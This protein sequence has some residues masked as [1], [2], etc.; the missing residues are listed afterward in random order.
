M[1]FWYNHNDMKYLFNAFTKLIIFTLVLALS[2]G[3]WSCD[4]DSSD[5][6]KTQPSSEFTETGNSSESVDE[7]KDFTVED[8]V[9]L[10]NQ[11]RLVTEIFLCNSLWS[12]ADKAERVLV[13]EGKAYANFSEI[14]TLV[15]QTYLSDSGEK[16]FFFAYPENQEPAVKSENGK[17]SV[18]RH[19]G[20]G[21]TDFADTA[22][23]SVADTDKEDVKEISFK[24]ISGKEIKAKAVKT[25]EGTWLLEKGICHLNPVE[26]DFEFSFDKLNQ[27]SLKNLNGKIL[28]I[29]LFV[30]DKETKITEADETFFHQKVVS[31]TQKLAENVGAYGLTP[32]FDFVSRHYKHK[33]VLGTRPVDFDIMFAQTNMGDLKTFAQANLD[34]TGYDN[35]FFVVCIKKEAETT[36]AFYDGT[37]ENHL[38][39]GERVL[40]GSNVTDLEIYKSILCLLGAEMSETKTLDK[41]N[42][43]LYEFYFPN[44]FAVTTDLA[45]AEI[46]PVTAY[47]CG[48]TSELNYLYRIFIP[49]NK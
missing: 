23:V 29:Q 9:K 15:S 5:E 48:F 46:S 45:T 2:L 37:E 21:Y 32:Q 36:F 3:L 30:S 28:V 12:G 16:E 17:T 40:A 22:T 35:Y 18:F 44:D 31:A 4:N 1:F 49:Q 43:S 47:M 20:S 41:Y 7:A 27:G 24:T 8:A 13:A 38:Y 6:D 10:L 25:A 11:D 33:N 34:L 42:Q 19:S 26:S 14:E 39:Q